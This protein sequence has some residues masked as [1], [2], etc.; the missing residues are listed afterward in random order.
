[1]KTRRQE[2]FKIKV[3]NW[4]NKQIK[5]LLSSHEHQKEWGAGKSSFPALNIINFLIGIS[6]LLNHM[7]V[8]HGRERGGNYSSSRPVGATVTENFSFLCS[9]LGSSWSIN[10]IGFSFFSIL[11]ILQL[12]PPRRARYKRNPFTFELKINKLSVTDPVLEVHFSGWWKR[13]GLERNLF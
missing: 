2:S 4:G 7:F 6:R 9:V 1:M 10:L 5:D 11:I 13:D 3:K 8:H 12:L